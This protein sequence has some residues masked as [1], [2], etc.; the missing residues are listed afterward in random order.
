MNNELANSPKFES[1]I[2]NDEVYF[3][4]P[5]GLIPGA[6]ISQETIRRAQEADRKYDERTKN[7]NSKPPKPPRRPNIPLGRMA[8]GNT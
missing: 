1:G 3:I 8:L 7:K 6:I 5:A 2:E 4:F